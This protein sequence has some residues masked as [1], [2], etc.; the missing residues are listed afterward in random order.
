MHYLLASDAL[1]GDGLALS[2]WLLDD[3]FG[4][5]LSHC[6]LWLLGFAR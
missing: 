2:L 1:L 4:P 5:A 6:I 3:R